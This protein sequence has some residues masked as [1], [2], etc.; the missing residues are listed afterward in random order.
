MGGVTISN[1]DCIYFCGGVKMVAFF[2]LFI[3]Y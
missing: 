1:N 2:L 3:E